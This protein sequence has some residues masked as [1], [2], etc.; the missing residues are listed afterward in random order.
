MSITS[1]AGSVIVKEV[2]LGCF[3]PT[4]SILPPWISTLVMVLRSL[5]CPQATCPKRP[6][7]NRIRAFRRFMQSS[8]K[9]GQRG[10]LLRRPPG[11]T[12]WYQLNDPL[13]NLAVDVPPHR[14]DQARGMYSVIGPGAG[15]GFEPGASLR[16]RSGS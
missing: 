5:F 12:G 8:R 4:I 7:Q 3:V 16:T 13:A 9:K 14:A 1:R 11:T 2:K 10:W 15:R 6:R